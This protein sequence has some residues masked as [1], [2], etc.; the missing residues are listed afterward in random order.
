MPP[1]P[2][3]WA[4]EFPRA[5]PEACGVVDEDSV[6]L[7]KGSR[8][9][10]RSEGCSVTTF[11]TSDSP[12]SCAEKLGGEFNFAVEMSVVNSVC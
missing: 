1:S 6:V 3:G 9:S 8:A 5:E 4:Q 10:A 11:F 7:V 12:A 2:F